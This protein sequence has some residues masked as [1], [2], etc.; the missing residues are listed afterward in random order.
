MDAVH[1]D[2]EKRVSEIDTYMDHV[3]GLEQPE[4]A[5]FG[6]PT[7]ASGETDRREELE[8]VL[9][10][11]VFLLLYNLVESTVRQSL[12]AICDAVADDRKSYAQLRAEIQ[13]LWIRTKH[14]NFR[15]Q[16]T[17]NIFDAIRDLPSELV[18]LEFEQK[19]A[20]GGN[21]DARKIREFAEEY[22]FSAK[23]HYRADNGSKLFLIKRR[24]NDLAHGLESF[25]ECGRQY[26]VQE[27][28]QMKNETVIYLRSILRNVS[29]YIERR[30]FL[31]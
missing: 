4:P 15:N 30:Q 9:K 25:A 6:S 12:V 31:R 20:S 19:L 22:G 26:S 27:L 8:K 18:E 21:L 28:A 17:G 11:T 29:R 2:F 13:Q 1:V 24:R 3:L 5:L 14:K 23:A 7:P 10:A 16:G